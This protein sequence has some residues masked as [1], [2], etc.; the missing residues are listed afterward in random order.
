MLDERVAGVWDLRKRAKSSPSMFL[1]KTYA[2][3]VRRTLSELGD[4]LILVQRL[5]KFGSNQG[6]TKNFHYTKDLRSYNKVWILHT[7]ITRFFRLPHSNDHNFL[8][9]CSGT[10]FLVSRIISCSRSLHFCEK[11]SNFATV[12]YPTMPQKIQMSDAI[13][14]KCRPLL[15]QGPTFGLDYIR[16]FVVLKHGRVPHGP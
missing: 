10:K 13:Q 11:F 16:H 3:A 9:F 15:E 7:G 8:S 1:W 14:P 5:I 2:A 12:G 6:F 4:R